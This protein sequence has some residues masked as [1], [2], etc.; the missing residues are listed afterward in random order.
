MLLGLIG[1]TMG[2]AETPLVEQ[3]E[4]EFERIWRNL[5]TN[6]TP[7]Y[8][9]AVQVHDKQSL[10]VEATH[11]AASAIDVDHKRVGDFDVRVG[12]FDLDNTHKIRDGSWFAEEVRGMLDLPLSDENPWATKMEM[13]QVADDAYRSALRRLIKVRANQ[14]VKV[15][16]EDPSPDFS[17]SGAVEQIQT[18]TPMLPNPELG[19]A[20]QTHVRDASRVFLDYPMVFDSNVAFQAKDNITAFVSSEGTRLQTQRSHLRIAA[21]ASTVADDGMEIEVYDYVDTASVEGLPDAD[22]V[23]E[24]AQNVAEQVTALRAA[25]LIEPYVGPAILRGR[26][27]AVFFHEILGH[28]VEGHRQKDEDEGQTLTDKVGQSIFPSFVSVADDPTMQTWNEIDLNGHYMFDDEGIPAQR[29]SV[30]DQ[31]VLQAFL[32]SRAPI[33]GFSVSNGHGRRQ[34]GAAVVA[35]QGNLVVNATETVPY[36]ELR[37]QLVAEIQRAEK[38]WGLIFDDISGGFTFTGRTTPNSFSVQP[39]TVW[40]VF[41]DGRPDEL[42]R[43]VD[44]IGTPLSTFGEIIGASDQTQVFNGTCGAESG[45]VPVSAIAPDLLIR[46]VEVQR[47]E[48]QNDRPPL[49]TPPTVSQEAP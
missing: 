6:E 10:R 22:A 32:M 47:S 17:A 12:S 33:E 23:M 38:P 35:R 15:D 45:W 30:V 13:W 24:L 25:P 29:V 18:P 34:P 41:A 14:S 20:W 44:L 43:G 26:A 1:T 39:V 2:H 16:R 5:Q 37:A 40:R 3:T 49:L 11:G 28:R 36:E 21:W 42:V 27:A 48:K 4:P 31:G 7:P 8:W 19:Q 9:M 46:Q